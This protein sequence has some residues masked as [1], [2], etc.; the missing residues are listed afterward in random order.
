MWRG[1]EKILYAGVGGFGRCVDVRV[2]VDVDIPLSWFIISGK[3]RP[4]LKEE[5]KKEKKCVPGVFILQLD[6]N[7]SRPGPNCGVAGVTRTT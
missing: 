5:E 3:G 6:R 2:Y 4:M 1:D 7:I